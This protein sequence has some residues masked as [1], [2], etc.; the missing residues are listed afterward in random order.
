MTSQCIVL[1]SVYSPLIIRATPQLD[2]VTANCER[3]GQAIGSTIPTDCTVLCNE[4][5]S[6]SS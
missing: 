1:I 2:K 4:G 5:D 3:D 6:T